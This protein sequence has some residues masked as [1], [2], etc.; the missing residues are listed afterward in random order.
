MVQ[1]E[2]QKIKRKQRILKKVASILATFFGIYTIKTI[3]I[4]QTKTEEQQRLL[5]DQLLVVFVIVGDDVQI[6]S[7]FLQPI[8]DSSA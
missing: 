8:F 3:R 7:Y 5:G 6:F 4:N 1:K 2:I